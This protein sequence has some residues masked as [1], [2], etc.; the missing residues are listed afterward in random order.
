MYLILGV[1]F[2]TAIPL[3]TAIG[4]SIYFRGRRS[5]LDVW[6]MASAWAVVA[7]DVARSLTLA[8]QSPD[9]SYW[10]IGVLSAAQL[11]CAVV[12][13]VALL[14]VLID[15]ANPNRGESSEAAPASDR[16]PSA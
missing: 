6:L 12:F 10:A 13:T 3:A 2:A 9:T 8:A 15:A 14:L 1:A 11:V 4:A 5:A 16:D 7:A